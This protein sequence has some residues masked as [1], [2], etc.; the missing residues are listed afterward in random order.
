[1]PD[2]EQ[3][4]KNDFMIEKIKARP[5]NKKKLLRRTMITAAMAVIFGLIACFTFLVL[6]PV[7]SK[8]LYPEE[9]PQVIVFPEDQEEMSPEEM[10]SENMQAENQEPEPVEQN[11]VLK[12]EQ[13]QEILSRVN[14]ERKNY[15]QLYIAMADYANEL[16][17][18]MVTVTGITSNMDW[19]NNM[20]ESK[21]QTSGVIIANNG[22]ELLILADN[23]PLQRA[24]K[25]SM[26][27]YNDVQV[28]AQVK[29]KEA[30]TNLVILSVNLSDL[31]ENEREDLIKVASLGSS[32]A[33]NLVGTPVVAV[34]SPLGSSGSIGYGMITA[35]GTSL[36]VTDRNYKLLLT[37]INGSQNACGVL[38]NLQGQILGIITNNK[39]GS[40]MKNMLN[41]YG[42]T[43][44]KKVIEKMTNGSSMAYLG[45]CGVDVTREVHDEVGV[46]YGTYIT[47][48]AMDSPAMQAG[49]QQGDILVKMNDRTIL[50]YNEYTSVLL[51]MDAGDT[52][53]ITIMRQ[54]Q[55]EYKEMEFSIVTEEA[56]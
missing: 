16:N 46:P 5:V 2:L 44:L 40:D 25:L 28:E 43:E 35:P 4:E 23:T 12:K 41:A 21:N 17:Q 3:N 29:R 19:F 56:E 31:P 34:G 47:E 30:Y 32:N 9:P 26:T 33:K 7:I 45:I 8:L 1:M 15:K 27:F 38:F 10:L 52:A 39:T 51:Q 11:V 53:D 55:D 49:I 50:T 48:V 6:E 36:S 42:I 20:Q 37:D 54:S 13:I 24:E 14:L 18:Y 22:K